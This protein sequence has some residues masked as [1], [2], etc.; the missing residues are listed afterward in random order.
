MFVKINPGNESHLIISYLTLRKLIGVL[1]A[2]L[3]L[4]MAI[5]GGILFHANIQR[6]ISAYYY[7]GMRDVFVGIL[8]AIG[9][10][11]I[12][13]HGYDLADFI[14]GKAG[15]V[16]ALGVALFPTTPQ[17][18]AS[19]A[20]QLVGTLHFASAALFFLT[21]AY[22]SLFLFTKT[23]PEKP[24]TPKKRQRNKVYIACGW[25]IIGCLAL[26]AINGL[27]DGGSVIPKEYHPVFWLEAVANG[28]FGVSW[29]TKGEALLRDSG[30]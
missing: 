25:T 19:P 24:P 20:A 6:S 15:G 26:I 21:I 28:A 30:K 7:T 14:A 17:G 23:D 11:L 22:F 4:V 18:H 2:G 8:C 10:F 3:P 12:S 29:L 13:Y 27:S 1:G 5:G 16:F 9:V